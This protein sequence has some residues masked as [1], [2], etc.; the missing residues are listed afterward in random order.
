MKLSRTNI[1]K[2]YKRNISLE[3]KLLKKDYENLELNAINAIYSKLIYQNHQIINNLQNDL[4]AI[5]SLILRVKRTPFYK[6]YKILKKILFKIVKKQTDSKY[7]SQKSIFQN[8]IFSDMSANI[9]KSNGSSYYSKSKITVGIISDEFMLNYYSGAV[10]IIYLSPENYKIK[11]LT[12]KID[13]ILFVSCWSGLAGE[14]RG[15]TYESNIQNTLFEVFTLAK[16]K[17]IPIVFQ[18]IEDPSN[19]NTFLPIAMKSDYIFTSD[20]SMISQYNKDTGNKNVYLL[21]YGVNPMFHNPVGFCTG[22]K[23]KIIK[24]NSVF[25]AG[26]WASRYQE[27]CVDSQM[28]FDGV[29]D[30]TNLLFIA[31]RNN[32]NPEYYFPNKYWQY[33]L[34][35]I[36]HDL[37]QR[38][39]KLFEWSINV[40]SIKNSPT[41][42]AM[43]VYELQALGSLI[44]SN[45]SNAVFN[46]FPN[47][48]LINRKDE[49]GEIISNYS[50]EDKY[51]MQ[52]HAI[53]NVFSQ[54]TVFERLKYIFDKIGIKEVI[55]TDKRILVVSKK[56]TTGIKKC[57]DSQ[58]YQNKRLVTEKE[59]SKLAAKNTD[60]QF[61]AYFDDKYKYEIYYLEDMVNAFKYTDVDFVTKPDDISR[62]VKLETDHNFID[63]YNDR[64]LAVFNLNRY[65]TSKIL[66]SFSGKGFGYCIDPFN[67]KLN[68]YNKNKKITNNYKLSVII[69]VYNNGRYL[70]GKAFY[71]LLRSSIFKEM[72]ILCIDDGSSDQETIQ[73]LEYLENNYSNV[74]VNRLTGGPSGSASRPRNE[75]VKFASAEHITYLDPDNEAV[76][77]GY[78][79]LLKEIENS[80]YDFVFGYCTRIKD[81]VST[82]LKY[83]YQNEIIYN[84]TNSLIESDFRA[85]SC[86]ACIIKKDFL[87]NNKITNVV[88]AV[89]QDTLFFYELMVNSKKVK[90]LD[91]QIHLYY[92]DRGDSVVNTVSKKF[93]DKSLILEKAMVDRLK[94]YQLLNEYIN[95]KFEFFLQNW[96]FDKLSLVSKEDKKYCKRIIKQIYSLYREGES[97]D[98]DLLD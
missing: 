54:N 65:D 33:I 7:F 98:I 31:D 50:E 77:D 82:D 25:F 60:F 11:M 6:G 39:H 71:S 58:T 17:S 20:S 72:E 27:R 83:L 18:T 1:E 85:I 68:I 93:F 41:M 52:V 13:F 57:F 94:K 45:Y 61:V 19:Y 49:I 97:I 12:E 30:T 34:P 81:A 23:A 48:F 87:V 28:I 67:V 75:G 55:N 40:N 91:K 15:V 22:N 86:Q 9:P 70:L 63:H 64:N 38:V 44:L 90:Y 84:P 26:S 62:F 95:R 24:K 92:V 32:G 46:T 47:I 59:F 76:N 88:G 29:L 42:C 78:A 10:N 51:K 14:W 43:R 69:P 56:I 2:L 4:Q 16:K 21:K 8:K 66:Q 53:R 96:Y 37:L 74:K 79:Y 36:S 5:E 80:D 35:P 3:K 73:I 89:G